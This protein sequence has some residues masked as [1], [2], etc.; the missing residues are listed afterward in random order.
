MG[1]LT[2]KYYYKQDKEN[3]ILGWYSAYCC[4]V[5]DCNGTVSFCTL[6]S[7]SLF[8][9]KNE[10]NVQDSSRIYWQFS[11]VDLSF[12]SIYSINSTLNKWKEKL[13]CIIR[14]SVIRLTVQTKETV[15]VKVIKTAHRPTNGKMFTSLLSVFLNET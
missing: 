1:A 12:Q 14:T 7:I 6:I 4:T 8:F 15:K 3:E 5:E 10:A 11:V 13:R 9:A 2:T